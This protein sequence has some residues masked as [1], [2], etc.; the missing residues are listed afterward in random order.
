MSV[1][2]WLFLIRLRVAGFSNFSISSTPSASTLTASVSST[3][4][5]AKSFRESS[6]LSK[7]RVMLK[8][9]FYHPPIPGKI[10]VLVQLLSHLGFCFHSHRTCRPLWISA[11]WFWG[12]LH[13]LP[14]IRFLH[15]CSYEHWSPSTGTHPVK[16]QIVQPMSLWTESQ[17]K[18]L[19]NQNSNNRPAWLQ[20]LFK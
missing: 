17:L 2:L 1:T 14:P 5:M 16:G 12:L 3:R 7:E 9:S 11:C 18:I 8:C 19:T 4:K 13:V 6:G 10:L 15:Y 20:L